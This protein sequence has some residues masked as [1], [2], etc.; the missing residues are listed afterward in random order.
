MQ[1]GKAQASSCI[2]KRFGFMDR[3]WF[4]SNIGFFLHPL[5]LPYYAC[6]HNFNFSTLNQF[7]FFILGLDY[8]MSPKKVCLGFIA[9]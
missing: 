9:N 4:S 8:K 1:R 5:P 2:N 6:T 3:I 7:L